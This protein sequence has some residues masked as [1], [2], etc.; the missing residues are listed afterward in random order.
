M[1]KVLNFWNPMVVW[2]TGLKKG[3]VGSPHQQNE[4]LFAQFKMLTRHEVKMTSQKQARIGLS[5]LLRTSLL[6]LNH[7]RTK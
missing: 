6:L 4:A 3:T 7:Y 1:E 5:V 2:F